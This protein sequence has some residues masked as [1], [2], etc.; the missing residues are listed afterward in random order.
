MAG[1]VNSAGP[2]RTVFGA[3]FMGWLIT[4]GAL[5]LVSFLL[6]SPWAFAFAV[7]YAIGSLPVCIAV[8]ATAGLIWLTEASK[9]GWRGRVH[10]CTFGA[11]CGA[12][13]G[14]VS[15]VLAFGWPTDDS[16]WGHVAVSF[17]YGSIM[18]GLTGLFAWLIRRPDRDP[19]L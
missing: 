4:N 5:I 15:I 19:P 8:A 3:A 1:E 17:A 7:M 10:Y 12:V 18:G 16:W 14:P 2:L 13:S 6:G 9:R 11:L